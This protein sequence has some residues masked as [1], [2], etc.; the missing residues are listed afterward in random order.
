VTK[1][2]VPSKNT[3]EKKGICRAG[4]VN[5]EQTKK[6]PANMHCMDANESLL[7]GTEEEGG[8]EIKS[9]DSPSVERA[10]EKR[11]QTGAVDG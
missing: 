6:A 2:L 7:I 11:K 3:G 5:C 9:G 10:A 4:A 8:G 1:Y